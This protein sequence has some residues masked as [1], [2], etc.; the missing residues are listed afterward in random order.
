MLQ[1][2]KVNRIL[3]LI[4]NVLLLSTFTIG[5]S[6][7]QIVIW[8]EDFETNGNTVNGGN[9]RY[10]SPADFYDPASDDDYWGR[11]QGGTE[12]YFLTNATTGFIC[13]T[14]NSYAGQNGSFFYAGEDLDDVGSTIGNPDGLDEKQILFSGINILL[15]TSLVFKGLF[16][17]GDN[18]LPCGSNRYDDADYIEVYYSID[19]G[20]EVLGICFNPDLECNIP[21][22]L[23]NEPLYHDNAASDGGACSGDGGGGTLLTNT[24]AEFTF[25]IAGVGS[26][27][28]IR[29]IAHMDAGNEEIAID[30]FRVESATSV[31]VELRAFRAN[32]M[33]EMVKL[34]WITDSE[35]DN[36]YFEIQHSIDGKHFEKIGEIQGKG[37]H[38]ARSDYHF[39]DEF[40]ATGVNYYRLKQ[41]DWNGNFD[42]SGVVSV[43][44]KAE[45]GT[46]IVAP[47]PF[48]NMV[49]LA[50][51]EP[52]SEDTDIVIYNLLGQIIQTATIINNQ[53]TTN[54]D[55][56]AF[57]EGAYI[58]R[59]GE[60]TNSIVKRIVK[61]NK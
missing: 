17:A 8:S 16:A 27:L 35:I 36:N 46:M 60:G 30:F 18:A 14:V 53:L 25:P 44:F 7:A 20:A 45:T 56:S 19:G 31:P 22:D 57:E 5:I 34:D 3:P 51:S 50:F 29:F 2:Y 37:N 43:V 28:D 21:G 4:L 55:L 58:L 13:N 52:F 26:A 9:G 15:G 33:D 61:I 49:A 10:A 47:N 59:V 6:S 42:H 23:T 12:E 39:M 48:S 54:I 1:L 32:K 24:F 38:S 41:V 11:C 40:P